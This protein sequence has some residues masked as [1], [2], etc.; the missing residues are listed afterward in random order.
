M[1]RLF[2]TKREIDFISDITKEVIK[3]VNGQ[4]I[5]YY[6]ISELKTKAHPVYDEAIKKI[7]DNPIAIEAFVD[8]S[9]EK[10]TVINQ[11]GVD[12]SYKCEV[13]IHYRDM[14]ERGINPSIGDYFTF[15]DLI[16]EIT[17]V[18]IMRNIYGQAEYA[19][20]VRLVGSPTRAD[21]IEIAIMG[22]TDIKYS[23][24]DAVQD[25]FIQKRGYSSNEEGDTGDS[26][27]LIES[28]ILEKNVDKPQK[29]APEGDN[30]GRNAFYGEE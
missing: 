4:V 1:A 10:D 27:A 25:K 28:G 8:N 17:E 11:F 15:S 13:F 3:D 12:K 19:D 29:V 2:L 5:Y 21:S 6:P 24:N 18:R 22:P 9:F 7:F 23:D 30:F 16:F 20:G 14:I 26:R